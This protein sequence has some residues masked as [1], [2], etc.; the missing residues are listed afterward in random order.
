MSWARTVDIDEVLGID[1]LTDRQKE[2]L[3]LYKSKHTNTEVAKELGI[4]VRTVQR[5]I[6]KVKRAYLRSRVEELVPEGLTVKGVSTYYTIDEETGEKK[7]KGQWVK[8]DK[9]K[10]SELE[11]IRYVTSKLADQVDGLKPQVTPPAITI[12]ELLTVYVTTDMHLGQYAWREEAGS[13][14]NVET[15]YENTVAAHMLLKDTTPSSKKAI[16]LDLGDTLHSSNDANRTKS[17]HE[18]DVDTR[19]AKVFK[20]LVDLKIAMID[21]A[22]EKHERVRYVIVPGNHSDLVGHY[23]IAMLSAYYRNESR[24][25][26]DESAAMHKYYRH[27]NTLLGFHHGHS[28]KVQRL[29]EVMVWDKKEDISDTDFRY[30]LTG[31]VHKDTVVDNP[32]CRIESF[33]NLTPNDAW[34]QGAGYRG[35]KQATA[36]T[37]SDKYGEVARNIVNIKELRDGQ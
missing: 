21:A 26:I 15:V 16:I 24:F 17:G 30:W 27:G 11:A 3:A 19:H 1:G 18:L 8:L 13:D 12:E 31:H 20:K 37:Y 14:V 2:V 4:S 29:P 32:I 9:S 34:A 5:I 36:I 25:E 33:R 10:E 22:L 35:H 7:E 6:E 23:L 28:T